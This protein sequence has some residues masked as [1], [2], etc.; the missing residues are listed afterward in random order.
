MSIE[1]DRGL[2]WDAEGTLNNVT[3]WIS[4]QR[5]PARFR[6]LSSSWPEDQVLQVGKGVPVRLAT[7]LRAHVR[8]EQDRIVPGVDLDWVVD[9]LQVVR[10]EGGGVLRGRRSGICSIYAKVRGTSIQSRGRYLSK[11]GFLCLAKGPRES[12]TLS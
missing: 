10:L 3:R 7:I 12:K 1:R 5:L 4:G 6:R 8:D 11:Y 9:D 2:E